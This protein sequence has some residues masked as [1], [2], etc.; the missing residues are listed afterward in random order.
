MARNQ[1]FNCSGHISLQWTHFI[2]VDTF[3]NQFREIFFSLGFLQRIFVVYYRRF[4][5]TLWSHLQ[6]QAVQD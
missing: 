5:T 2:A 4:G 3:K 6:G 1:R